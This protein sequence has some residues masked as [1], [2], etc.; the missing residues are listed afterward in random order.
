MGLTGFT[1]DEILWWIATACN[2]I[3]A[4][5]IL[6]KAKKVQVSWRMNYF[7]GAVLLLL[8]HG[9]CRIP[10]ILYD[11]YLPTERWLWNM[12]AILGL[13]SITIFVFF[14]ENIIIKKTRHFFTLFGLVGVGMFVV[15]TFNTEVLRI[16]QT[17][18]V[19]SLAL[20]VP[21]FY[22]I[23]AKQ[24]TG[25]VRR[26]SIAMF[27][28]VLVFEASQVAHSDSIWQVFPTLIPTFQILGSTLM[29]LGLVLIY[30][31]VSRAEF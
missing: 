26:N 11:Y 1:I 28:G 16:A 31:S 20:I 2:F 7:L 21:L 15:G 30:V 6:R 8:V 29:I 12:G 19:T 3:F 17:I 5:L 25:S 23:F 4:F 14:I 22:L 9:A 10:Y 27:F 18:F 24:T 13:I